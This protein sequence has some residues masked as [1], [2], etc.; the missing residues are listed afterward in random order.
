MQETRAANRLGPRARVRG[1]EHGSRASDLGSAIRIRLGLVKMQPLDLGWT[2]RIEVAGSDLL[3]VHL[4]QRHP[5]T[6]RRRRERG[7]SGPRGRDGLGR[8]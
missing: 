2:T 3:H 7:F 5:G 4:R 1:C 6:R 8:L